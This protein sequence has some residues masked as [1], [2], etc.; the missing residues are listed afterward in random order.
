VTH[1][2]CVKVK[3]AKMLFLSCI[4]GKV[5]DTPPKVGLPR[6]LLSERAKAHGKKIKIFHFS[7]EIVLLNV[8]SL[9]NRTKHNITSGQASH[10]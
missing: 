10:T 9:I 1:T 6:Q 4:T 2:G 8:K 3:S 5:F 7:P